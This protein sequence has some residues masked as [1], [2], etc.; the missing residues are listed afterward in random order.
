MN[1]EQIKQLIE[2]REP[3]AIVRYF[4]RPVFVHDYTNVKYII[5]KI[6]RNKD[7]INEIKIPDG[8]VSFLRSKLK[9][10]EEVIRKTY[11]KRSFKKYIN[12]FFYYYCIIFQ[13]GAI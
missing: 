4:E 3:I 11:K 12:P 2:G 13:S 10:F 1:N 7:G 8:L 5:L 6:N 9:N